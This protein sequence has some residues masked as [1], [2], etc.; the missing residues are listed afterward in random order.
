MRLE[1]LN[2]YVKFIINEEKKAVT[3]IYYVYLTDYWK[4]FDKVE[5]V[6]NDCKG[7]NE[8]SVSCTKRLS[9]HVPRYFYEYVGVAKCN[10]DDTFDVE[11]GK[12]IAL[13][14]AKA[15]YF[16]DIAREM[17]KAAMLAEDYAT[18]MLDKASHFI[19]LRSEYLKEAKE[20]K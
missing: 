18:A 17:S 1:K 12:R 15:E 20:G 5:R 2:P 9:C 10:P 7:G 4:D 14:R 13:K 8:I 11:V 6:F 19:A 3:C 16:D